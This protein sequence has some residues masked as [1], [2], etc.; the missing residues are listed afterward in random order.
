MLANVSASGVFSYPAGTTG[1]APLPLTKLTVPSIV[2]MSD[3]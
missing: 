3:R 2:V 1:I